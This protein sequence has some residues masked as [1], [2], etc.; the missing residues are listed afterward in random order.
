M[1]DGRFIELSGLLSQLGKYGPCVHGKSV[2]QEFDDMM[3]PKLPFG[4]HTKNDG[5]SHFFHG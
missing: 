2:G 3:G 5:K 1:L 4:K